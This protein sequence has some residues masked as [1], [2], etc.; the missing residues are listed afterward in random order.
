MNPTPL[1]S[2][3]GPAPLR[4]RFDA[5]G[6]AGPVGLPAPGCAAPATDYEARVAQAL[7]PC[8][9]RPETCA[10]L[11]AAAFSVEMPEGPLPD[12]PSLLPVPALWLL[13]RG[14]VVIGTRDAGG[15]FKET[16]RAQPGDWIDVF[17]T[18]GREGSWFHGL[19]ASE[20]CELLALP[21]AAVLAAIR[22]DPAAGVAFGE[23]L[24]R[25]ARALR[26]GLTDFRTRS[27]IARL[28][29]RILAETS[30][31]DDG[32]ARRQWHM[33]LRK[34]HLADQLGVSLEAL[35]RTFR[36][37]REEGVIDVRSYLIAVLDRAALVHISETGAPLRS[38]AMG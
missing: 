6:E 32:L 36:Q 15:S 4:A 3:S 38:A 10:R 8:A 23:V 11:A 31:T 28:A 21:V 34:R 20:P 5:L 9:V 7:V 12:A 24:C 30:P 16:G 25:Q 37:L 26:D 29:Q 1:P 18:L 2:S 13:H 14:Q 22:R 33:G 17:G 27:L 19:T 35:S